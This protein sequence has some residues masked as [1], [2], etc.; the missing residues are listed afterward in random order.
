MTSEFLTTIK[1]IFSP[2]DRGRGGFNKEKKVKVLNLKRV[3]LYF[4][5]SNL[6]S[7]LLHT[8]TDTY[9][10]ITRAGTVVR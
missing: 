4:F 3:N 8:D 10:D 9:S 6:F 7:S 2:L 1:K 5:F